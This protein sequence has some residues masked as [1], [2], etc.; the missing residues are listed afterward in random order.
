MNISNDKKRIL[1]E[2]KK[3]TA[4]IITGEAGTGKT[5]VGILGGQK[6]LGDSK[7]WE[8]ALYLTYSKLAKR[9]ISETIQKLAKADL[10][11]TET[12]KKLDVMNYH[13]FWWHLI[14][15]HDAFLNI[16][17]KPFICTE[18]EL[19]SFKKKIK[20]I[21][22]MEL[23]PKYFITTK[24]NFNKRNER[25]LLDVFSGAGALYSDFGPEHF[26][27]NAKSFKGH[28]KFLE[29]C[30]TQIFERNRSGLFS[31]DET[32]CWAYRL[33]KKH[34]NVLS[35]IRENYPIFIIDEFQDTDI[36]QWEIIK[37]IKPKTLV[38]MADPAQTIHIWRGADPRRINQFKEFC[39]RSGIYN[40]IKEG[41]LVVQHRTSKKSMSD[42]KNIEWE[43]VGDDND[44]MAPA[45]LN[46]VK[47]YAKIRCKNI[48]K[49]CRRDQNVAVM[50]LTNLITD[51]VTE[52]FRSKQVFESKK[53]SSLRQLRCSRYGSSYSPYDMARNIILEIVE[54]IENSLDDELQEYI[55]NTIFE[56]VFGGEIKKC[57]SRSRKKLKNRWESSFKVK[58]I[59]FDDFA[60]G[61]YSLGKLISDT[62]K[63]GEIRSD[64]LFLRSLRKVVDSIRLIGRNEWKCFSSEKKRSKIESI[65][66]QYENAIASYRQER[67]SIMTI[68][69]A[70]GREFDNVIIFWF[71]TKAWEIS[72]GIAWDMSKTE[73]R[74]LFHTACTR[75]KE[76]VYAIT[77]CGHTPPWPP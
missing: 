75:A 15:N 33:L 77:P 55:A 64:I 51:E 4:V 30:K 1:A 56:K 13:S 60:K 54:K 58:N 41:E 71:S 70:K 23:V 9:Q 32:V 16:S 74:N 50:C 22:P 6:L 19:D 52:F 7:S 20:R 44:L 63:N 37:L 59:L 26:G 68:H 49:N 66:L 47:K 57:S 53:N 2:L 39:E 48:A 40:D 3:N 14:N 27:E 35:I 34:P 24:G 61:L 73:H 67:I 38:V 25:K 10:L 42:L 69:Q 43:Y 72:E 45:Q 76:K 12:L 36:A 11:N 17:K 18:N 31:H 46:R 5:F 28:H 21:A 8:K 29:W 65:I 62:E